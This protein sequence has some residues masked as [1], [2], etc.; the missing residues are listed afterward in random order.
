ML[1]TILSRVVLGWLKYVPFSSLDK[2][3]FSNK[4][5]PANLIVENCHAHYENS[6]RD[7]G[8]AVLFHYVCSIFSPYK[9]IPSE[10]D[11]VDSSYSDIWW[12]LNDADS[13]VVFFWSYYFLDRSP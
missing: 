10:E 7:F 6:K 13:S 9:R 12:F 4:K 3:I 5:Y 8:V 2:L 11:T 1:I